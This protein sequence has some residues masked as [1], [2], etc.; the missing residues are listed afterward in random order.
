MDFICFCQ[1]LSVC[2]VLTVASVRLC[3]Q[4]GSG[5]F[6]ANGSDSLDAALR[7]RNTMHNRVVSDA[8]I[9]AGG[10]PNTIHEGNWRAFLQPDGKPSSKLIVEGANLFL[11]A[12]YH[13]WNVCSRPF[14]PSFSSFHFL[15]I[16]CAV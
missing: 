6:G 5:V 11:T 12:G 8:F 10:R 15:K 13:P 2:R 16:N 7:A 14:A 9:P 3:V 4:G 1:F